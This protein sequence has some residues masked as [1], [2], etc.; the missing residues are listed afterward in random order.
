MKP[1]DMMD[2]VSNII[3]ER[4]FFEIQPNY[5]KNIIIGFAR[6]N[7]R[8]IGIV[9]NQPKIAAGKLLR[10]FL[11]FYFLSFPVL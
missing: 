11:T 5:A 2:V 4:E 10:L 3:D 1:Y 6:I 8:P 9:A 7:G